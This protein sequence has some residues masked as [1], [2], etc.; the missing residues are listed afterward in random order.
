MLE[1]KIV[2][3]QQHEFG[4]M[5]TL[6]GLKDTVGRTRDSD[7]QLH[8]LARLSML[9][10]IFSREVGVHRKLSRLFPMITSRNPGHLS[11]F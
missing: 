5:L 11:V 3:I 8:P 1:K 4:V 7:M 9:D 6:V 10:S 2:S